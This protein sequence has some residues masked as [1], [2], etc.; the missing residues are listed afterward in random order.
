[1]PAASWLP[2]P[3]LRLDEQEAR[4]T[5]ARRWVTTYGPATV[6][7]LKGGPWFDLTRKPR[8]IG[9]LA[10]PPPQHAAILELIR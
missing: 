2:A 7:D 9:L 1:M 5:L 10:A 3:L 8:S 4:D 6:T